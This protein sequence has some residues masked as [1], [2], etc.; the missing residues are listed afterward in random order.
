MFTELAKK[1]EERYHKSK[2]D[3]LALDN[4]ELRSLTECLTR[5]VRILSEYNSTDI[6][7]IIASK[8]EKE[9]CKHL[10]FFLFKKNFVFFSFNYLFWFAL[11]DF[12]F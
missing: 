9:N 6:N 2:M 1:Q 5:R 12:F 4:E 7:N 8:V 10:I 3:S 11:F